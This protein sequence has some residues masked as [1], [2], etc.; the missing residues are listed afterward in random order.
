M[1]RCEACIKTDTPILAS[2]SLSMRGIKKSF[3]KTEFKTDCKH[4]PTKKSFCLRS[5][6][7]AGYC[8]SKRTRNSFPS[9]FPRI[10]ASSIPYSSCGRL[11]LEIVS[12]KGFYFACW[13][14][15]C[16]GLCFL[17]SPI[18]SK[19]TVRY[20]LGV[21]PATR[22]VAGGNFVSPNEASELCSPERGEIQNWATGSLREKCAI[23]TQANILRHDLV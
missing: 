1:R 5:D 9:H 21:V 18:G 15:L 22:L 4:Y 6:T 17:N 8:S 7:V 20:R 13:R 2:T 10:H 12:W 23:Q 16:L 19:L 11:T 14:W 3:N